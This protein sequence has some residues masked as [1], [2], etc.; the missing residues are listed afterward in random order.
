MKPISKSLVLL[1]ALIL[2]PAISQAQ[3]ESWADRIA[4]SGDLRLRYE[5]ID[6]ES[7]ETRDRARY[8]ARIALAV[9]ASDNVK[10]VMELASNADDPRSRNV[11]FDGGF[12]ADNMGFDLV[13]ADW[14]P[15]ESLHVFG[16]KMKNPL[17]RAGGNSLTWDSDLNPEGVALSYNKGLF[18]ANAAHFWVEERSSADNSTLSAAQVGARFNVGDNASLTAGAGYFAYSNTIG[19]EP[20]YEG[21]ADGNTV[22]LLGN[23]VY[24]Y[25]DTEIFVQF[26]TRLWDLPL[27]VFVHTTRNNEVSEQDSGTAYGVAIGSASNA[28]EWEAALVY[29][30]LEADAVIGTF[31]DSD[32]GGGQTDASG[33]I[34]KGKYAVSKNIAI[35]GTYFANEINSFRMPTE[36]YNRFQLDVEFKFK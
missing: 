12:S 10:V 2:L 22:D 23:Y 28:G 11:T 20:F 25:K 14:T 15:T 16:G 33:L 36:D 17:F 19:N 3:E 1:P 21:S 18:F 9:Q 30:D 35:G 5:E 6:R 7:A 32:F 26:D 31:T 27:Q 8:R 24:D 4:L 29:H 13:Y 34:I